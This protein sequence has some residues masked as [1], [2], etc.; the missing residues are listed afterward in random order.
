MK[1][2]LIIATILFGAFQ[3]AHSQILISLIFGDKLNSENVQFGLITGV[4]ANTFSNMGMDVQRGSVPLGMFFDINI[5]QSDRFI[6]NPYL[7]LNSKSGI[8]GKRLTFRPDSP[9]VRPSYDEQ[10]EAEIRVDYF[11]LAPLLKTKMFNYA[12]FDIGPQAS[13]MYNS[14][15]ILQGELDDTKKAYFE[16]NVKE[17]TRRIDAGITGGFSYKFMKGEG[18][19]LALRAYQGFTNVYKNESV[20]QELYN[21]K[22]RSVYLYVYIPIKGTKD[23]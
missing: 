17:F 8:Q 23:N 18:A 15:Y 12:Y 6:F 3:T 1:K 21:S 10:L 22:N 4:S 14:V 9:I 20:P 11:T 2:A 16:E 13:L 7:L 5:K 19:S